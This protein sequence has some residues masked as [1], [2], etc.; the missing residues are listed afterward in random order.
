MLENKLVIRF[1]GI[2]V[3]FELPGEVGCPSSLSVFQMKEQIGSLDASYQVRLL[4]KP[5]ELTRPPIASYREMD[6]YR[7]EDGEMRVYS[8]LRTVSGC[9]VACLIRGNQQNVL[10]YP[11]EKWD[12]YKEKW[13]VLHLLGIEKLL[14]EKDA[15]LLHSSFV[16]LNGETIL[17]SGP[18]GIGKSTQAALWEKYLDAEV[19]NGDR[20]VVRKMKN[21]FYG[22][23]SP[24]SGTSK[25]HKTGMAPMKGIFI[26]KQAE[27][28]SIRRMKTDA[29][30]EIFQQ[31]IVNTWNPEFV[32]RLTDLISE[33][34]EE[35]PVYELS[36]KPEEA[37]V[38]LAYATLMEQETTE[39][40]AYDTLK[41]KETAERLGYDAIMMEGVD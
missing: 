11:V 19:L 6:V 27:E 36:C 37:A 10:Y 7:C 30:R 23:G 14:L 15:F 26:L 41:K 17:F 4:K 29:F 12:F 13:H 34:L 3:G 35:V 21:G 5:L 38:R 9:Q 25:I 1:A 2:T 31:T 16:E 24:W 22:C 28:N 8:A 32:Q 18:S 20:C 39:G 33:L 40:L